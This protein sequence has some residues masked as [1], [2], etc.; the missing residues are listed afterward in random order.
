MP[1]EGVAVAMTDPEEWTI[2]KL[3]EW[4]TDYFKK[5][6]S[7]SSRLDAEILLSHV[8]QWSRIQLYTNFEFQPDG[9]QR[10]QFRELIKR[11]ATGAPVA[12]LIGTKEFY[13]MDFWVT[14]DVLIP[15]PETEFAV[16]RVLDLLRTRERSEEPLKCLDLCTGSG[17]IG[18]VLAAQEPSL[19][20]IASDVSPQALAV[21]RENIKRHQ[22]EARIQLLESDLFEAIPATTFHVIVSN[23]PY[24]G[25]QEKSSLSTDVVDHEP[26]IAL[27]SGE[28]G[29]ACSLAI[30]RQAPEFLVPNGWL[31][32]ESSPLIIDR[33]A[34]AIEASPSFRSPVID[35]DLAGH[36]RILSAQV[37]QA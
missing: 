32:M 6:G 2:K 17:A 28:D 26:G 9:A 24:I 22:L 27:F 13:S 33:L 35:R 12:H 23:P 11:R 5:N 10:S 25:L 3:L 4:T 8:L 31:V 18:I 7:D 29:C 19:Q 21:A 16:V 30:L 15:R 14:P 1:S 36:K 37:A 34:A 20:V